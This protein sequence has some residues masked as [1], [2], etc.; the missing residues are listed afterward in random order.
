VLSV[1]SDAEFETRR[2]GD[3]SRTAEEYTGAGNVSKERVEIV[4]LPRSK[5]DVDDVNS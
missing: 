4:Q 1:G 3:V 5:L 2:L